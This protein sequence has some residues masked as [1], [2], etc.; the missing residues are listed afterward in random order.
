MRVWYNRFE[1]GGYQDHS[2][3]QIYNIYYFVIVQVF[4]NNRWHAH[5]TLKTTL[6]YVIKFINNVSKY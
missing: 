5:V 1:V 3:M 4:R 2:D 6:I